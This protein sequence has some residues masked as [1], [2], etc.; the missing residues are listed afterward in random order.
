VPNPE[1]ENVIPNA[2]QAAPI[3]EVV[4]EVMQTAAPLTPPAPA[5]VAEPAPAPAPVVHQEPPGVQSEP[6]VAEPVV[7]QQPAIV[8]AAAPVAVPAPAPVAPQPL[9]MD[10]SSD[11]QQVETNAARVQAA[12]SAT[13][14]GAPKRIKRVRPPVE[15]AAN[16]PLQQV[17]TRN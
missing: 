2:S 7:V 5:Y 16:E 10:W 8:V 13:D 15:V 1:A 6:V 12:Q 4:R 14:D 3:E 9:K 17:E 11:L